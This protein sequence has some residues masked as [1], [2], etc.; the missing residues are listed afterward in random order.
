MHKLFGGRHQ[1]SYVNKP[2]PEP[3]VDPDEGKTPIGEL[4]IVPIQGRD[5]PNR[6]RFGKQNPFILFKLGNVTKRTTTDV[7]GGQRPRWK[8]DQINIPLYKSDAKDATSLYVTCLDEDH[9]KNDLIGD[10][11]INLTKVLEEGELDDWFELHYKGR[12]AGELMLQLTYYSH[13]PTHSTNKMNRPPST[14]VPATGAPARRPV[15]PHPYGSTPPMAGA[16][17]GMG[18]R[19]SPTGQQYPGHLSPPNNI[20]Q[21]QQFQQ[22]PP[23]ANP[24]GTM[25]DMSGYPS[26]FPGPGAAG[27]PLVDPNRRHSGGYPPIGYLNNMNHSG[28]YPPLQPMQNQ[29]GYPPQ[30]STGYPPQVNSFNNGYPPLL[31]SGNTQ[32]GYPPNTTYSNHNLYPPVNGIGPGGFYPPGQPPMSRPASA[33]GNIGYPPVGYPFAASNLYPPANI[34]G[35]YP[36]MPRPNSP[37]DGPIPSSMPTAHVPKISTPQPTYGRSSIP[38]AFPGAF[39]ETGPDSDNRQGINNG[40]ATSSHD[41]LSPTIPGGYPRARSASP[42]ALPPRNKNNRK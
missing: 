17:G 1:P 22:F 9:Q 21:S 39:P 24:Y 37:S 20:P 32:N 3:L 35:G 41:A 38:G 11:V 23:G 13:D 19:I 42:P 16:V 25:N 40:Q 5:L 31:N 2:L 27:Y 36:P 15:H 18:G 28:G 12:E 26:S 29:G 10:C 30:F 14:P 33:P 6:E 4:V 8:D 34:G 7:R